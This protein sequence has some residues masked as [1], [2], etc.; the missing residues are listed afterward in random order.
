MDQGFSAQQ[1]LND[2]LLAGINELSN[3]FRSSQVFIT[4]LLQSSIA[5]NHG[6]NLIREK[7]ANE[8]VQI[9]AKVLIATVEG[10]LHDIGKNLVK[11]M[12]EGVGCEVIDLGSDVKD[13]QIIQAVRDY[14]PD[15]VAL[16][17]LLTTTML[18]QES[19][20]KKLKAA[21]LRNQVKIIIGGA[22]V[23]RLFCNAIGADGYGD[24]AADA[25]DL[26]KHLLEAKAGLSS[27][28]QKL[29]K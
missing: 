26:V 22:P 29:V 12:L 7:L 4:E 3:R 21:G 25:V 11:L 1:I 19:V 28:N 24:D 16:S 27:S 9:R 5:M 6:L 18:H 20:I 23:T 15:I 13:E 14:E 8:D 10:D 2:G 17:S